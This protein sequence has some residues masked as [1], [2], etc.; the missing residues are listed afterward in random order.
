MLTNSEKKVEVKPP[1]KI[2][3][4]N[5]EAVEGGLVEELFGT[6]VN[7]FASDGDRVEEGEEIV[8]IEVIKTSM[9]LEAPASGT[10]TIH[11]REGEEFKP[12]EVLAV[13]G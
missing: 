1:E 7:W 13:I 5:E 3:E 2:W 10:L 8:E 4:D 11:V 6:V 9:P 12:G